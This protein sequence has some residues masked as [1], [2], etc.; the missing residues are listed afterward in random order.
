MPFPTST[1]AQPKKK[2][3]SAAA[4]KCSIYA[5]ISAYEVTTGKKPAV[6]TIVASIPNRLGGNGDK[7][8]ALLCGY[9]ITFSASKK[10]KWKGMLESAASNSHPVAIGVTWRNG[11][12]TGN[13]WIYYVGAD[14]TGVI[15]RDQQNG[16]MQITISTSDWRGTASGGWTYEVTQ[17]SLGCASRDEA[18][19]YAA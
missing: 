14:S 15:A 19:P 16:H 9:G 12:S 6:A 18:R 4:M 3:N 5:P 2:E 17:L 10:A 8:F 1:I 11:K 7:A 13:H